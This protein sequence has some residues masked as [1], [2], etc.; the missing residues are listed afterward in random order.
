[1]VKVIVLVLEIAGLATAAGYICVS[2]TGRKTGRTNTGRPIIRENITRTTSSTRYDLGVNV[3]VI[4]VAVCDLTT[5]SNTSSIID[6]ITRYAELAGQ[7]SGIVLAIRD[8]F[9]GRDGYT[10][11]ADRIEVGVLLTLGAGSGHGEDLAI[12]VCIN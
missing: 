4:V 5:D 3:V 12:V 7:I 11:I 9:G 8:D 10:D 2:R 1:M 6:V